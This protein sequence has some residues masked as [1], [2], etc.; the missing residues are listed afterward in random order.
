MF[1]ELQFVGPNLRV[2][3]VVLASI[4][5]PL[6]GSEEPSSFS[7]LHGLR[8]WGLASSTSPSWFSSLSL[9]L[10]DTNDLCPL[11][12]LR[13]SLWRASC[14]SSYLCCSS[15]AASSWRNCW[16]ATERIT[17]HSKLQV[18][19]GT[20]PLLVHSELVELHPSSLALQS[21]GL[22]HR[23]HWLNGKVNTHFTGHPRILVR[24]LVFAYEIWLWHVHL[25]VLDRLYC[26]L[27][28]EGGSNRRGQISFLVIYARFSLKSTR[29]LAD[30]A[31]TVTNSFF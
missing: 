13:A 11:R 27:F 22:L 28:W 9:Y 20:L 24:L 15:Y 8:T 4:W 19:D 2:L 1:A 18:S 5:L 3:L 21:L 17:S 25:C 29:W 16:L 6:V 30:H 14:C 12:F 7:L 26:Q 23:L 10:L 31:T